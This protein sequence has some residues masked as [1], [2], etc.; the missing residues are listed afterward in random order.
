MD[1]RAELKKVVWP[2]RDQ[3]INLTIVVLTVVL[4]MTGILW[5]IDA[6]FSQFFKFFLG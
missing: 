2:T 1:T 3:A 4:I 5:G 6:V